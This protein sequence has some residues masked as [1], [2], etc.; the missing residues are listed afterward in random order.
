M[1]SPLFRNQSSSPALSG[2]SLSISTQTGKGRFA[3]LCPV[4]TMRQL[5]GEYSARIDKKGAIDSNINRPLSGTNTT[6]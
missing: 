6:T 5:W 1:E 3:P 2:W 4:G